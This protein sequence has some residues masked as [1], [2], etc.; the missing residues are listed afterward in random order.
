MAEE[1]RRSRPSL[2]TSISN[3]NR[4]DLPFFRRLGVAL[5]NYGRRLRVPPRD[6]CGNPGQPGC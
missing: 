5:G 6:C 1:R 3:W 2:R 4:S